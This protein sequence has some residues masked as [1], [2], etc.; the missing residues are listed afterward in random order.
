MAKKHSFKPCRGN[1]ILLDKHIDRNQ[2]LYFDF[3]KESD[4]MERSKIAY[5]WYVSAKY[6]NKAGF[7]FQCIEDFKKEVLENNLKVYKP[8]LKLITQC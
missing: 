6:L 8:F 7:F 3:W 1:R 5:K 2:N 4:P